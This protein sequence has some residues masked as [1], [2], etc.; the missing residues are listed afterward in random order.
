[1]TYRIL[2]H[3]WIPYLS[4]R[5]RSRYLSII[6]NAET[7]SVI[8]NNLTLLAIDP[9][10]TS[11]A[12]AA[13]FGDTGKVAVGDIPSVDGEMDPSG[14]ALIISSIKPDVAII[15]R[16]GARPLDGKSSIFKFGLATGM[17]RGV[18][19]ANQCPIHLV[20]PAVWKRAAGLIGAD[21]E[22]SRK[23]AL[24]RFPQCAEHLQ[25]KKQHNRA[26]ALLLLA[27][28]QTTILKG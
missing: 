19:A 14:F 11:G 16:V 9:G 2:V 26:E 22:A 5:R 25:L 28:L 21:K 20:T 12:W 10:N 15:E 27:H 18:I 3:Y 8:G 1:M 6:R 7:L 23:L 4:L 17:A 24:Q 13:C